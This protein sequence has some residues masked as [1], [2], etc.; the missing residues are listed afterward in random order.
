MAPESCY[1]RSV[2]PYPPTL[3]AAS[4]RATTSHPACINWKRQPILRYRFQASESFFS[5]FDVMKVHHRLRCTCSDYTRQRPKPGNVTMFS[6]APVATK[7]ASP[8][9]MFL[10]HLRFR[11][12]ISFSGYKP[13]T[14]AF[15]ITSTPY[16]F[17]LSEKFFLLF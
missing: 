5:G 14:V 2:Y 15:N 8:F 13:I 16:F 7:M 11:T 4:T 6:L 17:C 12:V 3:S 9:H 10:L 1:F